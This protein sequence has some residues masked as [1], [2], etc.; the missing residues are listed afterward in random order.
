MSAAQ[1]LDARLLAAHATGHAPVLAALYS[2]AA[3]AAA[4]RGDGD[5]AGFFLTHAFVYALEAGVSE[6]QGLHA[7]LK[8]LGRID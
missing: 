5:A 3:D 7:R 4:A 8:E 6:A 2:E 1:E